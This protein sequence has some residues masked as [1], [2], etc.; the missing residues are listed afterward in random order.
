MSTPVSS[1]TGERILRMLALIERRLRQLQPV[2]QERRKDDDEAE[3]E[4]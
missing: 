3:S 1:D 4:V 2:P